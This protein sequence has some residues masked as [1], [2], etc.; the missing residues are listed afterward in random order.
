M[1]RWEPNARGR[2]M[3]AALELFERDGF[4]ATTTARI[5]ERAGLTER[6]FF[7]HFPDKRE[8]LF[9]GAVR[10]AF[11]EGLEAA[12][13][14]A[15]ALDAVTVAFV[16]GA[17]L[18]EARRDR[19]RRRQALIT[20]NPGLRE[21]ELVKYD[22]LAVQMVAALEQRGVD[23]MDARLAVEIGTAVY[24]V[25]LARWMQDGDASLPALVVELR[26]RAPLA[27]GSAGTGSPV[28][29]FGHHGRP[30]P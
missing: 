3:Q 13:P 14:E 22:E 20:A 27:A 30:A 8:A 21:R 28:A 16:A 12:P 29:G 9:T 11:M 18:L 24:R 5:A 15:S 4:E 7:R 26:D 1:S 23:P 6:T 10:G 19:S 17:E 25:A 2:L